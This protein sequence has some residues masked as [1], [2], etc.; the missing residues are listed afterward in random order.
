[1]RSWLPSSQLCYR[2]FTI[3]S[4]KLSDEYKVI[5][6]TSDALEQLRVFAN[7]AFRMSSREFYLR[8]DNF[9]KNYKKVD[10][11]PN[12]PLN[13]LRLLLSEDEEG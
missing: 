9:K 12:R 2:M 3:K 13:E 1:M 8:Y 11:K 7:G 10:Y 6:V 4:K 5:V